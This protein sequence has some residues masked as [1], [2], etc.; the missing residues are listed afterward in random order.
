[1]STPRLQKSKNITVTWTTDVEFSCSTSELPV[2]WQW[3]P[4]SPKC[5]DIKGPEVT[6]YSSFMN[7]SHRVDSQRFNNRLQA[8]WNPEDRNYSL[9]LRDAAMSDSGRFIC[10]DAH[11]PKEIHELFVV[12]GN[13]I[14]GIASE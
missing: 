9:F 2:T 4:Q 7:G 13:S 12:A 1:S 10:K 3:F 14:L 8:R 11:G 6:I 5:A